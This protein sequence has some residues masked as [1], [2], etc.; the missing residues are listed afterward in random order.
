M[1]HRFKPL[2]T[3]LALTRGPMGF[4]T[5]V[6]EIAALAVFDPGQYLTL[7]RTITL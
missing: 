5:S 7:G 6:I 1:S 2:H 3:V 4:L